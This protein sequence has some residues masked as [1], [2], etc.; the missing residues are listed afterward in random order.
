M[1]RE[2][3]LLRCIAEKGAAMFD[4][5]RVRKLRDERNY[6]LEQL[7]RKGG[8]SPSFLS[9]L[10]RGQKQPSLSTVNKLAAALNVS[11]ELFT[12][13]GGVNPGEQIRGYRLERG[14]SLEELAALA[15]ISYSYLCGI[16]RG[17]V[18]PS[19]GT[20]RKIAAGLGIPP[21]ELLAGGASLGSRLVGAREE[22]GLNRSQLARKAG[23]SPGMI[24]QIEKEKVQP[25]LQTVEKIATALELSP[26]YF[27]VEGDGLEEL[28]QQLSPEVRALLLEPKVQTLLSRLRQCNEKEFRLILDFI[29][30]LKRANLCESD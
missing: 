20:L 14:H 19:P 18:S 3:D 12:G 8:L 4:G 17:L 23:L 30:L 24:G 22:R 21:R 16:E 7:A 28:L 26:C 13:G 25:S 9:E 6:S 27:L 2:I 10:E 1:S 15:G 29:D 11:P 5:K